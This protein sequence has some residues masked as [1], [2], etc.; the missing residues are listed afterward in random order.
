MEE[1]KLTK[2]D[3]DRVR[4]IDGFP[5]A[6][7]ED[8][9]AL[10]H[11]PY[12]TACPNPFIEDFIREHGTPHNEETDS[13]RC[14]PFATDVSEGK[15]EPIYRAHSYHT[16]VPY[17]AIM[18]YILHYTKPSDVIFDGFCG[19]GML[20]V[21]ADMCENA[22][23]ALKMQLNDEL[24]KIEWG[25]R[26][27]ILGDLSPIASF[28]S[29]SFNSKHEAAFEVSSK[30]E[31]MLDIC[32]KNSDWMY[33]TRHIVNGRSVNDTSGHPI[34]GRINYVIWSDV[35]ICPS[36]SNEIVFCIGVSV[37]FASN[38]EICCGLLI[39]LLYKF[40]KLVVC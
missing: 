18:R 21:A 22:D 27:A 14:E 28:I 32:H 31:K 29:A 30:L 37:V 7:D 4:S 11:P 6:K 5:I 13:Y 39:F 12:Y 24:G 33:E 8:I 1:R 16:K 35:L 26:F 10:S 25:E 20:G 17:K 34:A 36:C 2:E 19:S 38:C 15:E 3:I 23:A 9:I 40:F